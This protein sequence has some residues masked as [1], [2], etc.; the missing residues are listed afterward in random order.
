MYV[1]FIFSTF[2]TPLALNCAPAAS[3]PP[4][5][6]MALLL[7]LQLLLLLLLRLLL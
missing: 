4:I 6:I 3:I 5:H 2:S 1:V 7:R